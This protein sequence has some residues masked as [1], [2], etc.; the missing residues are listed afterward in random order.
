M[1]PTR[2]KDRRALRPAELIWDAGMALAFG[3]AAI[4]LFAAIWSPPETRSASEPVFIGTL[5]TAAAN[6]DTISIRVT[7]TG[8]MRNII[9]GDKTEVQIPKG[10]T[11]AQLT[12]RLTDRYPPLQPF[13]MVA[14]NGG[15]LPQS[16]EL[17]DGQTVELMAPH[18][19]GLTFLGKPLPTEGP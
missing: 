13:A 1:R 8:S 10:G 11:V 5:D 15:M 18:S 6:S 9:G 17:A 19:A 14:L 3:L 2:G 12:N 16:L 7:A 4:G